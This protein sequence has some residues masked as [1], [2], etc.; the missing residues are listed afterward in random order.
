MV[1]S[2]QIPF[3]HVAQQNVAP[4]Q[5]V[6][7]QNGIYQHQN[8]TGQVLFN[9]MS[10]QNNANIANE[11]NTKIPNNVSFTSAAQQDS[12][13]FQNVPK[14]I[15]VYQEQNAT[16]QAPFNHVQQQNNANKSNRGQNGITQKPS[17]TS[18]T[19]GHI[20]HYQGKGAVY[21][22]PS[23]PNDT[24]VSFAQMSKSGVQAECLY[25]ERRFKDQHL[26][27]LKYHLKKSPLGQNNWG[28]GM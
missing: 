14:Q 8:S 9:Q 12:V 16:S 25:C 2:N 11:H 22:N 21:T 1:N 5:N 6:I 15:G 27:D 7:N 24:G 3:T 19:A 28:F 4:N 10:Q 17:G 20:A 13:Q 23:A 18:R 26:G